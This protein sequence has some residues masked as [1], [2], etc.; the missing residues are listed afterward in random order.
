MAPFYHATVYAGLH[1]GFRALYEDLL[2]HS[3]IYGCFQLLIYFVCFVGPYW[4]AGFA[5]ILSRSIPSQLVCLVG[6]YAMPVYSYVEFSSTSKPL[7]W[8]VTLLPVALYPWSVIVFAIAIALRNH[9][10]HAH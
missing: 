5:S 9:S 8:T 4:V 3:L 1:G 7:E 6:V 2:A 10:N